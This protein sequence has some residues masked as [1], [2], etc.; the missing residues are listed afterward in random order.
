MVIL[1][2]ILVIII[3]VLVQSNNTPQLTDKQRL[4]KHVNDVMY[5]TMVYS[6][7]N[8][9]PHVAQTDFLS[10]VLRECFLKFSDD[11][12]DFSRRYNTPYNDCLAIFIVAYDRNV[13]LFNLEYVPF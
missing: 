7:K 13:K 11:A 8:C 1:V 4:I 6:K 9:P 2:I 3:I 5:N 10:V 12:D